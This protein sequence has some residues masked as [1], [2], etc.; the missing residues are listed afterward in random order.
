MDQTAASTLIA[1]LDRELWLVT[2]QDGAR[3][4]GLIA[5]FVNA[6]SIVADLPR[7]LVSLSRQHFTWKLVQASGAMALHLLNEQNL[8]WV[9]RFGLASGA[10]RDKFTGLAVHRGQTGS[11]LLDD[12]IGWMDC[13]VETSLDVGDRTVY[14]VQVVESRVH[15]F[16]PPLTTRRL[17]EM[18]P[19]DRLEEMMRQRHFDSLLDV[20]AIQGWRR[21]RGIGPIPDAGEP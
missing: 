18:S 1:W 11:P 17:V 2:A 20:E 19:A 4:S 12:C 6:A 9:W 3:R 8:D 15:N 21:E 10:D 5:T 14:M 7:M 16:A 13:R